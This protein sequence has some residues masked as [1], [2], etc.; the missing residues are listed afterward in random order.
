[1]SKSR[2]APGGAVSEERQLFLGTA[3]CLSGRRP[4]FW[5][6]SAGISRSSPKRLAGF[7][8][9]M[10]SAPIGTFEAAYKKVPSVSDR[11]RCDGTVGQCG[12]DSGRLRLVGCGERTIL[13]EVAPRDKTS[14]V[15]SGRVIDMDSNSVLYARSTGR[16]GDRPVRHGRGECLTRR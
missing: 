2:I 11:Q 12:D 4:P 3:E 9:L 5:K 7:H 6:K 10:A 16:G 1:M 13:E 8:A 14:N 15:V